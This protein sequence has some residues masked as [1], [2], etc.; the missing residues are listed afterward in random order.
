MGHCKQPH[1][2]DSVVMVFELF[3]DPLC[4]LRV[5]MWR[6]LSKMRRKCRAFMNGQYKCNNV[7][8]SSS[9]SE[10][11]YYCSKCKTA[12]YCSRKCQKYDW[13]KGEHRNECPK[14]V[15]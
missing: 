12:M 10:C 14:Y 7:R 13:N 11:N 3:E 8:C 5:E 1:H 9:K 2:P 15:A 4:D 6:S